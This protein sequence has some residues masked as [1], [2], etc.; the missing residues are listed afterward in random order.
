MMN[1]MLVTSFGQMIFESSSVKKK[2]LSPPKNKDPEENQII[3][4][5]EGECEEC[6]NVKLQKT[7]SICGT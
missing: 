1:T 3:E 5:Y 4:T 6:E 7:C 2:H